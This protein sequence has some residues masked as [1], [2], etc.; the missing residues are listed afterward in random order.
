M[1][2]NADRHIG[3]APWRIEKIIVGPRRRR[4]MGDLAALTHSIE[5]LGPLHPIVIRPD[6]ALIAGVRR[7]AAPDIQL[8]K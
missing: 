1:S 5:E 8:W 6:G 4:A 7:L 2:N 3:Q